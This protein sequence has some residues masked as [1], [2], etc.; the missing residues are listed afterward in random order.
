MG[1]IINTRGVELNEV[2]YIDKEGQYTFKITKF[3]DDGFTRDSGDQKF[4]LHFVGKAVGTTEPMYNHTEMFN[5]GAK[6]LWRIKQLEVALKAPEC[7]DIESFINRYVTATIVKREYTKN[8]GTTGTAYNVKTW[9]YSKL[10]DTLA[11][12]PEAKEPEEDSFASPIPTQRDI[13]TIEIDE[14]S[15]PF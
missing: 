14:D 13:P 8:D 7:Y 2:V 12:I 4:K 3:E 6:S 9:E 10:N 15:I 5:I 1:L 11:P